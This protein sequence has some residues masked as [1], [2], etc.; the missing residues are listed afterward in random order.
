MANRWVNEGTQPIIRHTFLDEDGALVVPTTI[1]YS[2]TRATGAVVQT[3]TAVTAASTVDVVIPSSSTSLAAGDRNP[4]SMLYT[5]SV[6]FP[7]GTQKNEELS[8][9]VI[10]LVG[11]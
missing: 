11:A 10:P 5:L 2:I 1:S 6:T 7:D 3:S 4:I 8:F 9:L